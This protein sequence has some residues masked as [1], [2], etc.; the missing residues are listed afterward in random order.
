MIDDDIT[1]DDDIVQIT[2]GKPEITFEDALKPKEFL[3]L[4]LA[5]F[6]AKK[7]V[8]FKEMGKANAFGYKLIPKPIPN[9]CFLLNL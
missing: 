7:Y 8:S 2:E 4:K 3:H 9:E 6:I 1:V 5:F